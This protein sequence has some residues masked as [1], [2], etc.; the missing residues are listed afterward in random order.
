MIPAASSPEKT[1]SQDLLLIL[2][3]PAHSLPPAKA[4]AGIHF[5][6]EPQQVSWMPAGAGMVDSTAPR[7]QTL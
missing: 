2:V 3:I 1:G 6:R 4:G 5:A 7:Q